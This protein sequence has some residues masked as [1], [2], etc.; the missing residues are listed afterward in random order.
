[1]ERNANYL[2]VGSFVLLVLAMAILFI[3]WYS[4]AN[5]H[6]NY[7]RYEIYFDGSVA[8]LT[9]GS[10]VRYLGVDVGQVE[11][12]SIDTRSADRVQA[13][14]DIAPT[15]PIT[16]Q[17]VAQLSL[18]G[19]TGV[20]YV[21]LH[22]RPPGSQTGALLSGVPS[23][24]YPVI[25]SVHSNLDV[26]LSSLPQMS[27]QLSDLLDR[28]SRLLS[29]RNLRQIDRITGQ[30]AQATAGLPQSLRGIDQLVAQLRSSVQ[31]AN[32]IL[33]DVHAAARPASLDVPVITRQLRLASDN[34]ARAS[35]RLDAFM[36]TNGAQLSDLVHDGIPQ[37][38]SLLRESRAAVQQIDDLARSL[39][40][41]PSSLIYQPPRAGVT[42]PP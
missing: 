8:G 16:A 2:A 31:Q 42:I 37:L 20:M 7:R 32:Q 26:L 36:N 5:N 23:E 25:A 4:A 11:R 39:R 6:G 10:P 30:L 29:D 19:L 15:T 27:A 22:R 3:Y 38:E 18:Q 13:I 21:D 35:A 34:L 12:I 17:T 1:M 33:S 14:V 28:A 41:N 9:I 40:E 24:R